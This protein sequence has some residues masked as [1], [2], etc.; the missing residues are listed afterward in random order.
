MKVDFEFTI[1]EVVD[2]INK[3]V[4]R[5]DNVTQQGLW[6]AGLAVE[7][8]AKKGS[9]VW[10]GNLRGS[11]YTRKDPFMDLAVE[12]GFYAFYAPYVHEIGPRAGGVGRKK[13]LEYALIETPI[14]DILRR[15]SR[16]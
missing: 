16:G 1:D 14:L 12:V 10:T 13:F 9:P 11:G 15:A 8:N 5:Q 6:E 2:G 4:E 7:R 3:A